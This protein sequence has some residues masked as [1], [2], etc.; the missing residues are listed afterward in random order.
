M[1]ATII[2]VCFQVRKHDDEE[3]MSNW[4]TTQVKE[5]PQERLW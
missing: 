2:Y 1:N 3:L 4:T 5:M